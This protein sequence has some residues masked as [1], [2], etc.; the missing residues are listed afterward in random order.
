M[1]V[2]TSSAEIFG[3]AS[4]IIASSLWSIGMVLWSLDLLRVR[5]PFRIAAGLWIAAP[6]IGL[7]GLALK[8]H[9][10]VAHVAKM[11][12]ILGFVAAAVDLFKV[13]GDPA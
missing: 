8:D 10:P 6:V 2:R 1:L 3:E 4:Y 5:G 13:R 11:S 7:A 12:F 9:G